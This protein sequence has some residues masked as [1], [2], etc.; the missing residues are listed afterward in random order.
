MGGATY[1]LDACLYKG[2]PY[3]VDIERAQWPK[4]ACQPKQAGICQG[5][6]E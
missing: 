6:R 2:Q 5:Y 1:S 4:Q 3:Y